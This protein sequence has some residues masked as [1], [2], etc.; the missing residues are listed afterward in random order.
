MSRCG[1]SSDDPRTGY[2]HEV[3]NVPSHQWRSHD[4]K[5]Q[6]PRNAISKKELMIGARMERAEDDIF[7]EAHGSTSGA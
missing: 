1:A 7:E 2:V 5:L 6:D 3:V 4:V